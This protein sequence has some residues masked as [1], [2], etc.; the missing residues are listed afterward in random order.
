MTRQIIVVTGTPGVGKTTISKALAK[1][2]NGKHIDISALVQRERLVE[3][4][5]E[6]RDT[7]I[8]DN[9]RLAQR[10]QT[11]ISEQIETI[12]LD[13]HYSTQAFTD[14][15]IS[16]VIVVRLD[17]DEL[18]TRL[19]ARGYKET[20]IF[21]NVAAEILDVCLFDAL[22]QFEKRFVTEINVTNRD[23]EEIIDIILKTL[24]GQIKVRI[25]RVNWLEKLENEK[26]LEEFFTYINAA[27]DSVST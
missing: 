2:I 13:G 17:P 7:I 26:R 14:S 24:E 16:L 10:L 20:K 23:I 27:D 11:I 8:V 6:A 15:N 21:E 1:K 22:Q 9:T 5:D 3:G 19:Q 18:Q 12:I 25:G 4:R